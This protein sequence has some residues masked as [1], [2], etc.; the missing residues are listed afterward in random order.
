VG[1]AADVDVRPPPSRPVRLPADELLSLAH[2]ELANQ[3]TVLSALAGRL[4]GHWS[5]LDEVE[6]RDL[7]ARLEAECLQL[8]VLLANL[9]MARRDRVIPS[10]R[11]VV[12]PAP[13]P[14]LRRLGPSLVAL[15]PHHRLVLD[16]DSALPAVPVDAVAL[17]QVLLNAVANAAKFSDVGTTIT[18]RAYDGGGNLCIV[19]DDE[20]PGVPA[21]LRR[22]AFARYVQLDP[23]TPG[24]GLGL[25]VVRHLIEAHGGEVHLEDAPS[26]G[27]RLR[28]CL[29]APSGGTG[30]TELG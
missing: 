29:P 12:A 24:S 4:S 18:L 25:Y 9:G 5:A 7:A 6:R 19:V 10:R 20:G 8:N 21:E 3:A 2:H 17:Q 23:V 1:S 16:V 27:C 28:L 13:G 26:G 22:A 14:L 30:G 11:S 15:A